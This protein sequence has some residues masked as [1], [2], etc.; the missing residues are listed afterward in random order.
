MSP[1]LIR[2]MSD[3]R[4][5][6][7]SAKDKKSEIPKLPRSLEKAANSQHLVTLQRRLLADSDTFVPRLDGFHGP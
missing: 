1:T 3:D 2:R 7:S 6:E 5:I 4:S